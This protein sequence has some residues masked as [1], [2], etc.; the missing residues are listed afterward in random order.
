M[1]NNCLLTTF[2]TPHRVSEWTQTHQKPNPSPRINLGKNKTPS[3]VFHPSIS[4]SNFSTTHAA[5]PMPV[6]SFYHDVI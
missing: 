5:V 4:F 6:S 2:S 3:H 1:T